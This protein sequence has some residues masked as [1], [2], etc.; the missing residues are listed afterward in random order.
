VVASEMAEENLLNI[1]GGTGL[2]LPDGKIDTFL[3]M[4]TNQFSINFGKE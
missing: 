1:P 2:Q 3:Q 4:D